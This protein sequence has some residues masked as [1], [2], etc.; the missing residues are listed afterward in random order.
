MDFTF[1]EVKD[2]S[3]AVFTNHQV[4]KFR[5]G[6]GKTGQDLHYVARPREETTVVMREL[7]GARDFAASV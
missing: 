6:H 7:G 5:A 3:F 1:P 4:E 2:S